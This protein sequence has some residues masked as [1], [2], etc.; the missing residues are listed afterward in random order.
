[1]ASQVSRNKI[2]ILFSNQDGKCAY[3]QDPL[4]EECKKGRTPQIDH[5]IPKKN[6]GKGGDN[7]CLACLFCNN[8]KST[9]SCEE[10]ILFITPYLKGLCEKKDLNEYN[11]WLKLNKKFL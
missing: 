1:M 11:Q 10:F 8:S 6:G 4:I 7:L 5:I 2:L 9:K 3:C